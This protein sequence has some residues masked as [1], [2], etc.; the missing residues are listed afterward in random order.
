MQPPVPDP[1]GKELLFLGQDWSM[2]GI[3]FSY[4]I[5]SLCICYRNFAQHNVD[6]ALFYPF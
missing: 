1:L 5:L 2:V 6:T 4:F 3:L